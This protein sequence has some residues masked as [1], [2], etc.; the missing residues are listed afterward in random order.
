MATTGVDFVLQSKVATQLSGAAVRTAP[1][2]IA[3]EPNAAKFITGHV[4]GGAGTGLL[5]AAGRVN[6]GN[7]LLDGFSGESF[8]KNG[9]AHI[10]TSGTTGVT[11]DLTNLATNTTTTAGD[12]VFATVNKIRIYNCGAAAMT[13]APGASNPSNFP[14]FT[15]TTP[16]LQIDPGGIFTVESGAGV[17]IDATHKT[18]LIT[19]T[20]GGDVLIGVGGA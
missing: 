12:T 9:C 15:G 16:T 1:Y 14:K 11:V 8:A 5:G 13:V 18:I 6:N 20:A 3:V 4:P 7:F 10:T 2:V 17:T 19:P